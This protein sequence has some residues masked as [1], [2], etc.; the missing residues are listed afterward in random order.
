MVVPIYLVHMPVFASSDIGWSPVFCRNSAI[1]FPFLLCFCLAWSLLT[2]SF[3]L[4]SPVSITS[5][6]CFSLGCQFRKF[7]FYFGLLGP[8]LVC[9]I[10]YLCG[11]QSYWSPFL[12][13]GCPGLGL[14]GQLPVGTC[15]LGYPGGGLLPHLPGCGFYFCMPTV[16]LGGGW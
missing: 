7:L 1:I 6:F 16:S 4:K 5:P 9:H 14:L 12:S 10:R 8:V 13:N 2:S 15:A 3:V 11:W